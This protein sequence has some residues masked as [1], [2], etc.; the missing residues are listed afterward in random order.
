MKHFLNRRYEYAKKVSCWSHHLTIFHVFCIYTSL[1]ILIFCSNVLKH[2][3]ISKYIRANITLHSFR[4]DIRQ[5]LLSHSWYGISI[6]SVN[7]I[8][9][10]LWGDDIIN[11]FANSYQLFKKCFDE[12]YRNSKFHILLISLISN[13]HWSVRLKKNSFYWFNLNLNWISPLIFPCPL[14]NFTCPR[15]AGKWVSSAL[16]NL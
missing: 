16:Q 14:V 13:F 4:V 1:K 5:V 10:Q 8:H 7:K 3:P 2:V 15:Q 12:N 6:I 11:S 9:G